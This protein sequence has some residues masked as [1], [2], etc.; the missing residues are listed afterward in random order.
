MIIPLWVWLGVKNGIKLTINSNLDDDTC[1]FGTPLSSCSSSSVCNLKEVEGRWQKQQTRQERRNRRMEK[2][3]KER[4]QMSERR[5][6]QEIKLK[7]QGAYYT[8]GSVPFCGMLKS[9]PISCPKVNLVCGM[10]NPKWDKPRFVMMDSCTSKHRGIM[11]MIKKK[12]R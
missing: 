7:K 10:N 12:G 4:I 6:V 1:H 3:G 9:S 2:S 8:S 11:N 5:R